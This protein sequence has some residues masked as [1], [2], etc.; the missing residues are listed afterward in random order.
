[1]CYT[2]TK[3]LFLQIYIRPETKSFLLKESVCKKQTLFYEALKLQIENKNIPTISR[4]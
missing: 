4:V 2:K 3:N 1:M